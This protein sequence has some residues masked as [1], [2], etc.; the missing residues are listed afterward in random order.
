MKLNQSIKIN[1]PMANRMSVQ[2]S[3]YHH[4]TPGKSSEVAFF[5]GQD[6]VVEPIPELSEYHDGSYYDTA[7]YGWVPNELVEKFL[8][9]YGVST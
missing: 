4:C 7:V 8:E 3:E 6:W 2:D 5:M 9:E 1:H